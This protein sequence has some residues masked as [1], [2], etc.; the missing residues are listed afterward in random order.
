VRKVAILLAAFVAASLIGAAAAP[1]KHKPALKWTGGWKTN[2]GAMHLRQKGKHVTGTYKW[3]G[4]RIVGTAKGATLTG[5]WS[6]KPTYQGSSDSGSFTFT[7]S[8]NGKAFT[9]TWGY[10]GQPESGDWHGTR[11]S[12]K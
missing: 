9:G 4:G 2:Y 12:K 10:L 11:K 6:Q 7:M 8:S 1:A 3:K 5:T